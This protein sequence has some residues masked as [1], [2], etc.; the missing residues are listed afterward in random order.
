MDGDTIFTWVWR[1]CLIAC[2]IAMIWLRM[3]FD[4][5]QASQVVVHHFVNASNLTE[6]FQNG[7]I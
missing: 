4:K 5:W 1:I 6:V 2:I 7:G 3:D